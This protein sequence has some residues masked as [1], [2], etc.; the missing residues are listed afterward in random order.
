MLVSLPDFFASLERV[1]I[2][3]HHGIPEH[4]VHLADDIRALDIDI[5]PDGGVIPVHPLYKDFRSLPEPRGAVPQAD[6]SLWEYKTEDKARN[7]T[8]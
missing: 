4:S 2:V 1:L 5:I 3:R 7:I 6:H 8:A